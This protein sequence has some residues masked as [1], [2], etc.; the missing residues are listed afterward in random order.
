MNE[1]VIDRPELQTPFARA[2]YNALTVVMWTFYI[3]LLLPLVTLLAWYVGFTAV[4]EEMVMRRGWEALVQLLG[5]YSLIILLIALVQVGWA[6]IN[7]ARFCGTRDRRRLR[8]RKVVMEVK[9][10]FLVDTT[11]MAAWQN[12]K[13]LVVH[14]HETESRI[15]SVEV[16]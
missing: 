12:A 2:F 10:M 11:D 8:E 14:H 6:S 1:L 4:Y 9:Q 3:Y 13:R 7:W 5:W 16:G 15:T